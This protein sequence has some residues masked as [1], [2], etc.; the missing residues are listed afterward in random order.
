MSQLDETVR[1]GQPLG[2]GPILGISLSRIVTLFVTVALVILDL[3]LLRNPI[4]VLLLSTAGVGAV[5]KRLGD[6]TAA[7]WIPICSRFLAYRALGINKHRSTRPWRALVTGEPATETEVKS[8]VDLPTGW[9]GPLAGIRL[10]A[11][12]PEGTG[13]EVG[14]LADGTRY[15][16]ML[17][18][19]GGHSLTMLDTP[20]AL[21]R[22]DEW[23][24]VLVGCVSAD[25]PFSA[26]QTILRLSADNGLGWAAYRRRHAK[27]PEGHPIRDN[28]KTVT[29]E[30]RPEQR[31]RTAYLV[32]EIDTAKISPDTLRYSGRGD[33][34]A[35]TLLYDRIGSMLVGSLS[36][37]G[38]SVTAVLNARAVAEAL[39]LVL[40]PFS[41]RA[42][43][44]R[45]ESGGEAGV[46][47]SAAEPDSLDLGWHHM[48]CDRS[49]LIGGYVREYPQSETHVSALSRLSL[50]PQHECV[51]SL[52]LDPQGRATIKGQVT[53]AHA[54]GET[55]AA[56]LETWGIHDNPFRA[57]AREASDALAV[58]VAGGAAVY[59]HNLYVLVAGRT[60]SEAERAWSDVVVAGA[61]AGC[62]V[63]RLSGQQDA[64][65][66]ACLPLCRGV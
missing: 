11:F 40:D 22:L 5:M 56:V 46:D 53:K 48:R 60:L 16:A 9:E 7:E 30:Q 49:W 2:R 18:I 42:I 19:S 55:A 50:D 45:Q 34:G 35:C 39:R 63:A 17:A 10:L 23:G 26:L 43:A 15:R 13:A 65:I 32:A 1:F 66:A 52:V 29:E 20:D 51:I 47:P 25:Q 59:R 3:V 54:K 36:A 44:D 8:L 21:A 4:I 6:R 58:A 61:K 28:L 57:Q 41:A 62:E 27:M 33:I 38:I 64:A 31:S 37:A 12:R 24:D 14:V